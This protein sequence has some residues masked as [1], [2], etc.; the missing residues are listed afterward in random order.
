MAWYTVQES[1][2]QTLTVRSLTKMNNCALGGFYNLFENVEDLM[3]HVNAKSVAFL[4]TALNKKLLE[5]LR[6]P[7]IT[8]KAALVS[9]GE[10]YLIFA[11]TNINLWK[12]LFESIT[13]EKVP[14]WYKL[15]IRNLL[16]GL[17]KVLVTHFE[18]SSEK[19]HRTVTLF[20]AAIHG[21]CSIL[22]NRKIYVIDDFIDDNFINE[23]LSH[24][25]DG[26]I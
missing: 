20:W 22:I 24:C 19:M 6:E 25:I 23:Y 15:K 1:G 14:D 26:L 5:T 8:L 3:F 7:S 18:V 13:Q 10:E 17:E 12:S 16:N 9:L 11:K 2:K 4:F 21:I